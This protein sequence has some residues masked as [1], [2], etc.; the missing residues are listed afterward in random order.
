MLP[1]VLGLYTLRD[2]SARSFILLSY[3]SVSLLQEGGNQGTCDGYSTPETPARIP[4]TQR[5]QV[6]LMVRGFP[7]LFAAAVQSC[8]SSLEE[9]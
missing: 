5:P 4:L 3:P 6:R 2:T 1:R 9:E 8:P 7:P